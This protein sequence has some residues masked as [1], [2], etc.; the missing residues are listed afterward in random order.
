MNRI[1]GCTW[2]ACH[3]LLTYFLWSHFSFTDKSS[4]VGGWM[5][6]HLSDTS[7]VIPPMWCWQ[8]END[9]LLD[10]K[11]INVFHLLSVRKSYYRSGNNGLL[12]TASFDISCLIY[13]ATMPY[14]RW[15]YEMLC[16]A[17]TLIPRYQRYSVTTTII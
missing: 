16:K 2:D 13:M 17:L 15:S 11:W 9:R 12:L 4:K 6:I 8:S 5:K 14:F 7:S 3:E 10:I 1:V